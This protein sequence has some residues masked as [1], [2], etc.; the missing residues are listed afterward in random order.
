[1]TVSLAIAL[2]SYAVLCL[3]C[4][5]ADAISRPLCSAQLEPCETHPQLRFWTKQL[6]TCCTAWTLGGVLAMSHVAMHCMPELQYFAHPEKLG[7]WQSDGMEKNCKQKLIDC[8]KLSIFL[9]RTPTVNNSDMI[10]YLHTN[11]LM[12][13]CLDFVRQPWSNRIQDS[14]WQRELCTGNNNIQHIFKVS[15]L[16]THP[17]MF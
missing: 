4:C 11:Q 8:L 15:W 17:C 13:P 6:Q 9:H 14:C 10:I 7:S 3:V 12:C 2:G 16:R 5:F 1:M